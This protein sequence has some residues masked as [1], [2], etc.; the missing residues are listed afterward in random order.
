M[1]IPPPLPP[2]ELKFFIKDVEARGVDFVRFSP[3]YRTRI[4]R[5]TGSDHQAGFLAVFLDL[6]R[7]SSISD[8]FGE[9]RCTG[10]TAEACVSPDETARFPGTP[11]LD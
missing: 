7:L 11:G 5:K 6:R 8:D 9:A 4:R 10:G 2:R 3:T 1:R